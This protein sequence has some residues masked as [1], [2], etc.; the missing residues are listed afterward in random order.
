MNMN[1]LAVHHGPATD[2]CHELIGH[3]ARDVPDRYRS[4]RAPQS[5]NVT[6]DDE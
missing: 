2:G 1:G 3:S 6:I 4:V 5:K